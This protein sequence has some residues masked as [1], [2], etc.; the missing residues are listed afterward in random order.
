M[1][2]K[3]FAISLLIFFSFIFALGIDSYAQP[4][5]AFV[6]SRDMFIITRPT[7][8]FACPTNF[9]VQTGAL[10][11]PGSSVMVGAGCDVNTTAGVLNI[12]V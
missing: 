10:Q 6:I 12:L 5:R 3:N 11:C 9:T 2:I 7:F 4:G 8:T 1:K